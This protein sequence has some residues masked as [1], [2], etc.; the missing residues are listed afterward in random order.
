MLFVLA[1]TTMHASAETRNPAPASTYLWKRVAV[2]GGGFI[3]GYDSDARG[4]TRVVRADVH[5]AYLWDEAQNRWV[6]LVTAA[7]MPAEFRIQRGMDAGAYEVVVAPSRPERI[8]LAIKGHVLR[9]DDRGQSFVNTT[10]KPPFPLAFDANSEFRNYG[11]FMAIS[12]DDPDLVLF[13][14]PRDGLWRSGD[15]GGQWEPVQTVPAAQDLRPDQPGHQSPGIVLWFERRDGRAT[16]RIWAMSAG[17]GLFVSADGGRSFAPLPV[18]DE[19]RPLTLTQ[20]D[21]ARDGSFFGVD[22]ETRRAWRYRTGAWTELSE[23]GGLP[24]TP[25]AAV[26]VDPA[27]DQVFIFDQGGRTYRSGNGGESWLRLYRSA[28]LEDGEPP[29]LEAISNTSYFAMGR[30][31]FD[32]VVPSR[33]WVGA[34]AGVFYADT[35]TFLPRIQWTSRTRGIEELVATDIAQA[36]GRAPLFA[37]LDFG[38]HRKEDL[39]VFSTA[40]GPKPRFIAAQQLALSDGKPDF[41]ATNASDTRMFCCSEDGDSVLAG[42]SDDAGRNWLKFRSLPTPPGTDPKDPWRMSFGSIAASAGNPDN[43]VWEPAFNRS[44]FYTLDR[45]RSWSRVVLPGEKLPTTGSHS[46]Q[47]LPRKTL[48]ADRVRPGVFYLAHSGG[49]GNAQLAGL[50]RTRDG[51]AS[52]QNAHK[53]EIMPFSQHA[54]KLR[55]VPGQEGH[56]FFTSALAGGPDARLRRSIDGGATWTRV[57]EVDRVDDIAFGKAAPGASYPTL[58]VSGRVSGRYGIWRSTDEARSWL[59]IA[60]FPIGSLDTVQVMGADPDR[61]GRVY[62]GYMGSAFIYGEPAPCPAAPYKFPQQS[63]CYTPRDQAR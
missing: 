35:S 37:F 13:G 29:W 50:W 40:Y 30:V 53:G 54:A 28:R 47:W 36:P 49:P 17:H 48:A 12:P 43:I 63:E 32:P 62:L 25:F 18:Q 38:I 23:K 11:P 20:G 9:S 6:Q 15:G 8:Y 56:L 34:G 31:R 27:S 60:E 59:Q 3:T 45:G 16:G 61:F 7:N 33:L 57:T 24:A 4:L 42:Y 1:A 39:D 5:G 22:W 19:P 46:G 41:V 58:F 2:G 21:F 55:A 14:S 10:A 44:P 51:G 26:A 52:W